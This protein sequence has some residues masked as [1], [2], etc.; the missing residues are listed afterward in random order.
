MKL[1]FTGDT[2]LIRTPGTEQAGKPQSPFARVQHLLQGAD[3]LSGNLECFFTEDLE[4]QKGL[5]KHPKVLRA[6]PAMATTLVE[7]GFSIL[8][9]ANNH[10]MDGG[11]QGLETTTDTLN[12]IGLLWSGA[13]RGHGQAIAP[14]WLERGGRTL[15]FIG[16]GDNSHD[17]A[18]PET[19]GV[20]PMEPFGDLL[21]RTREAAEQADI[22]VVQL[23]ADLEFSY[24]PAPY[25]VKLSRALID[26][27]ATLVIQHHPHV[28]QGVERYR[29]GLIAYSLG[30]FVFNVRGNAYQE[31]FPEARYG[32]ILSVDLDPATHGVTG[33]DMEPVWIADDHRPEPIEGAPRE[34]ALRDFAGRCAVLRSS[35]QLRRAWLGRSWREAR[36][37]ALMAYYKSR[38]GRPGAAMLDLLDLPMRP[39]NRFWLRALP[40]LG[41]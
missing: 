9:L 6:D 10:M 37:H 20:A 2:R 24:A 14:A 31:G 18:G 7:A 32:W 19:P 22:V 25:R 35:R 1:I 30:N 21:Q 41:R 17:Y 4:N 28:V 39:R 23:H 16:A 12:R 27:G 38:R 5:W 40:L 3:V 15:A 34:T 11:P 13:G 8:N 36:Y 26:H 33:W 29:N